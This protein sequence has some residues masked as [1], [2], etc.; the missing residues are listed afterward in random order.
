[1]RRLCA[2]WVSA[3]LAATSAAAQDDDDLYEE[4]DAFAAAHLSGIQPMSFDADVEFCGYY[5]LDADQQI[6]ATPPTRGERDGCLPADPPADWS[7]LL[8]SWHT[9]GAYT[10]DA[11]IEVPSVD[12]LL[13]DIAE[14]VDGY[15]ATPGGRLWLNVYDEGVSVLLCGP[16]CIVA[17]PDFHECAAFMPDDEY[18][19]QSLQQRAADDPGSC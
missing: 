7:E 14:G 13:G 19:V 8:A 2:V 17:D 16:G 9:H 11:D 3:L 10:L 1:M 4:L 6:A 15:I 12:D 5:G 18:D